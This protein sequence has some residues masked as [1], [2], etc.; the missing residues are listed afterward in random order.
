VKNCPDAFDVGR[1]LG[2][3][4]LRLNTYNADSLQNTK[5]FKIFVLRLRAHNEDHH[6]GVGLSEKKAFDCQKIEVWEGSA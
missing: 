2:K 3:D 5:A 4:V 6:S 1:Q